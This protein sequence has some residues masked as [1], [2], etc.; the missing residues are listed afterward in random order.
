MLYHGQMDDIFEQTAANKV[1]CTCMCPLTPLCDLVLVHI[2]V[3]YSVRT[4]DTWDLGVYEI[5]T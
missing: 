5:Q 2:F 4:I 1:P 3:H